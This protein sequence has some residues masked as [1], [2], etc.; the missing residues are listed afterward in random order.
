MTEPL[1][2]RSPALGALPVARGSARRWLGVVGRAGVAI[3]IL[4]LLLSRLPTGAL[5]AAVARVSPALWLASVAGF[6]A[7]HAVTA[8][9][10]GLLVWAAGATPTPREVARAHAAGLFANLCL[11]S[12][13]GGDVVRLGLLVRG[14]HRTGPVAL[15]TLADRVIDTA[16]L[17]ALAALGAALLPTALDPAAR[18]ALLGGAALL[19]GATFGGLAALWLVPPARWPRPLDRAA[20]RAREAL[21]ELFDRPGVALVAF[22]LSVAVQAG[23]VA[24]NVALGRATGIEIATA[25]WL[26]VSPLAKLTA[27]LPVSL[28]GIGVREA[29]YVVLLAPFGVAA[30]PAVAQSLLWQA[31]LIA[32]GL[33]AGAL[34]L[35]L[36]RRAASARGGAA[37]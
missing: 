23:F 17:V 24:I 35:A 28:G 2:D 8:A 6:L 19:A 1:P 9:K 26:L 5:G 32:G 12:L 7:G 4:A 15:A 16:A 13:V 11:P 10:W 27:L 37:S 14:G 33:V 29:T 34:A 18:A 3:G 36:G 30:A 25:A 22:A 21:A 20:H 31:V